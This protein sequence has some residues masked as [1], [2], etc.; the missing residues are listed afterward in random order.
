VYRYTWGFEKTFNNG[1]GSFGMRLPL[2]NVF[3][4]SNVQGV[5]E[6]GNA[7]ALG[8]LN[9]VLKHVFY[10]DPESGSLASGGLAISPRTG[11]RNFGGATFLFPSNTTTFQPFFGFYLNLDPF[12]F[13]GFSAFEFPCDFRQPTMMYNDFGLGYYLYRD[14][15]YTNF[16]STVAPTVEVH[17][18]T[19]LNHHGAYDYRDVYGT[20]NIVD[21]TAG[22]NVRFRERSVLTLGVVTP[23]T[24]PR[25]FDVEA[26]LLLNVYYG[27]SRRNAAFPVIGG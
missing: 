25:P 15:T 18:N 20:P 8:D 24:G 14:L 22:L 4:Q 2:D 13:H 17:V 5:K 21:I 9:L 7:T 6:G 12:Y 27:R 23:V 11:P 19:P 16:V 10:V 26:T 1:L 3:A